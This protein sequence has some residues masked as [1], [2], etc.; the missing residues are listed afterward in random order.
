M[1]AKRKA[2][3]KLMRENFG[4]ITKCCEIA[5]IVRK[6]YYN[7]RDSDPEFKEAVDGIDEYLLDFVEDSLY[8]LIRKGD[9]AATI[10]YLK[11]K[12]K[13]RGFVERQELANVDPPKFVMYDARNKKPNDNED[14]GK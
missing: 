11:T 8:K 7:W 4:N 12:G 13:H 5:G 10:F 6:T 3:V 2:F 1:E 9:K 14:K